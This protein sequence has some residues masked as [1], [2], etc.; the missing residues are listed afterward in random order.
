MPVSSFVYGC[1]PLIIISWMN[2]YAFRL[3][4]CTDSDLSI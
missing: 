2:I 3:L 4:G 1:V